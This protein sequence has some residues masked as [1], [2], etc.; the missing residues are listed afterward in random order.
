MIVTFIS[1]C[2]KNA[3]KKSRRVLDAYANRIGGRTW[4]TIITFE[5]LDAVKKN[6]RKSASKNTAVA[7]HWVR[8][9][10]RT[11]LIWII[12]N[13]EKFNNQGIVPV[14]FTQKNILN[15]QWENDW[16]FLPLIMVL[17]AI[18]GLLHD[19]G[20]ASKW[21][22]DKLE[23][24]SKKIIGDPLRHEW[25]SCLFICAVVDQSGDLESDEAWL[26]LLETGQIDET[27]VEDY[28]EKI[29][30]GSCL[31]PRTGTLD[32]LPTLA[33]LIV[34]TILSHHRLPLCAD[35]WRDEPADAL[36]QVLER[37]TQQWG[38]ENRF[39]EDEFQKNITACFD[40]PKGLPGQSPQWRKQ[41]KR[42]A[43][44][45]RPL[46]PEFK[47]AA[48]DGHF[49]ILLCHARLCLMLAD[50][51]YSSQ[52][53]DPK[54]HDDSDLF[55][56]T[57]R[58]TGKLKQKLD[59]HLVKVTEQALR[60]AWMQPLFESELPS[61]HDIRALKM[62][63]PPQFQWQDKAVN[64]INAYRKTL[65]EQKSDKH[66]PCFIINMAST[67]CGKTM[68]NAKVMRA[69]SHDGDSLRY[70]LALGLR[71][72]TLQTG[73]EYRDR[74]GL[75]ETELAVLIGS[76]AVIELHHN[77]QTDDKEGDMEPLG[78][79]GAESMEPL[80]DGDIEFECDLPDQNL[81]TVL[82]DIRD[83]K[84]LYAPV[85]AC[86]I[87]HLMGAVDTKRG[88]RY[89]LPQLR[90]MSSDLVIDEIDDFNGS[91]LV[92]I[93]R[94]I[95]LAGMLGRKVMLSS[96]T[97]PPDLAQGYFN[98]YRKGWEMFQKTRD[99][100]KKTTCIWI[101]EFRTSVETIAGS[102]IHKER[103]R[104]NEL[105]HKFVDKRIKSLKTQVVKRKACIVDC[106]DLYASRKDPGALFEEDSQTKKE[107]YFEKIKQAVIR[108]HQDNN[109]VDAKTKKNVSFGVIRVANIDPCIDLSHYLLQTDWPEQ[110]T[111]KIMTYHSRQVLLLRSDQEKHLDAVLKR[112]NEKQPAALS[113]PVLRNH[114]ENS[115]AENIVFILVATPV[116]EIGRDH[117]FDWAIVEPSSYRSI[118]QL[119][120]RILRHRD[121][122][123]HAS[124]I[125]LL[126][127]NLRALLYG[128]DKPAYCRPGFEDSDDCRL[129]THDLKVLVSEKDVARC[130]DAT[131]R[132]KKSGASN[133][134]ERLADLEHYAI[135]NL[136]TDYEQVG[137]ES[138]QGWL[139]H[140]WWLTA[141]PQ[142]INPFRKS[143]PTVKR[144]LAFED[145]QFVFVEK[146]HTGEVRSVEHLDGI[147]HEIGNK[148]F[149]DRL[150]LDRDYYSL[151][152]SFIETHGDMSMRSASLRYGEINIPDPEKRRKN[153]WYSDQFG[154]RTAQDKI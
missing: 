2:E 111:P 124:N 103:E 128:P 134:K 58:R 147:K 105:H 29:R 76:K 27:K 48:I 56:N 139:N 69:L 135:S 33:R 122:S 115:T 59:E 146:T 20:K 77:N 126:Q 47:I 89:I 88:G 68:A 45:A 153:Y 70:V 84:L 39:E 102:T 24:F 11:E 80:M 15:S 119:A 54:W 91:D 82:K 9:R 138:L 6:L 127:Y 81:T 132:I 17:V 125:A 121:L 7:C 67:G 30:T 120:G 99:A 106:S 10:S 100:G 36:S 133:P 94:L 98:A 18:S 50:H 34:W 23:K 8:S 107:A 145:D 26:M 86:T 75:D 12:G 110:L 87:D 129:T 109:I 149:I 96:A 52:D 5:G 93:G 3:L 4:Q 73:D 63:S 112:K 13:R 151:L 101:D 141:L 137:P 114:M 152:E 37:I 79:I 123:P 42:W 140:N 25:I 142:K 65:H 72:L 61:A 143:E 60:F 53:A 85:L 44:K 51:Y 40:F 116:E 66:Q 113:D 74:I 130:I 46:L 31:N 14:N 83:R 90:L 131:P 104:Y 43:A 97:I 62:K 117:D 64:K 108:M 150:W 19:W 57:D 136:L 41:A 154:L 78:N 55:A 92:A 35:D 49:R 28:F 118:I 148:D 1:Q 32:K 95:H 71:T 22:Q 21:F 38:Y 144:F 16:H